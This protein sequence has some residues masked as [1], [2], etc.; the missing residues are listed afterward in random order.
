MEE[1]TVKWMGEWLNHWVTENRRKGDS[2]PWRF[3]QYLTKYS[4]LFLCTVEN[5]RLPPA[6]LEPSNKSP[7]NFCTFT[8]IISYDS[9]MK[10]V[11][12]YISILQEETEAEY[13]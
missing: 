2:V 11:H 9:H 6:F 7:S 12:L 13:G 5:A 10:C 1:G 8:S 4:C 3:S